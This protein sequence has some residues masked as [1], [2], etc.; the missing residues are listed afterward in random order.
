MKKLLSLLTLLVLTLTA[1]ATAYHNTLYVQENGEV[2]SK[3]ENAEI[4]VVE[5][6]DGKFDVT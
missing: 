1:S 3:A 6:S 4:T 2:V 5:K